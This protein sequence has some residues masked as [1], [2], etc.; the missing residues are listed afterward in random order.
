MGASWESHWAFGVVLSGVDS[1]ISYDDAYQD[2]SVGRSSLFPGY[3]IELIGDPY[4]RVVDFIL[5]PYTPGHDAYT[6]DPAEMIVFATDEVKSDL[7][8]VANLVAERYG[9][10]VTGEPEWQDYMLYL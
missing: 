2:L 3:V 8:R 5:I 4:E 1:E 10:D 7:V 9:L 6:R